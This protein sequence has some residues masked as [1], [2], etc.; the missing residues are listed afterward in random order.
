MVVFDSPLY[1]SDRPLERHVTGT[2]KVTEASKCPYVNARIFFRFEDLHVSFR[3]LEVH[4]ILDHE[5][6]FLRAQI[7]VPN[8]NFHPIEQVSVAMVDV[9]VNE[10]L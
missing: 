3:C 2:E 8:P 5:L 9:P 6:L 1:R 10:L 7:E 4:V